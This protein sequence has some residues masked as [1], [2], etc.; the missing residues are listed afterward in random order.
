MMPRGVFV[1]EAEG[2]MSF[3]IGSEKKP[4]AVAN[5]GDEEKSE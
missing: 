3:E 4:A 2:R 1:R 5:A